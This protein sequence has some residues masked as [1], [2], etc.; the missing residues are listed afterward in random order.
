[1][2]KTRLL[3][4]TDIHGS[5]RCFV[6]FL[7]AGK[8]YKANV[9]I[10]GGD[11]TGKMLVP[12][13]KQKDGSY[14]VYFLGKDYVL[15]SSDEV[16]AFIQKVRAIGYYAY[17]TTRE[18]VE[19]FSRD[20]KK[21]SEIFERMIVETLERWMNIAEERLKGLEI[22]LF[23]SPG[24][25]D[26]HAVDEVLKKHECDKIIYCEE[27]VVH[28]D[29]HHEMISLGYSNITPWR[30]PRDISEEKFYEKIRNLASKIE[31]MENAIFN[32]HCPPAGTT[33]DVAPKLDEELKP[34]L[35]LG[36]QVIMVN[37]GSTAVRRAIEEFQPL[38]GL[39]GHIHE[40][41]GFFKIGR[42]L[43]INPGSEYSEGIL[44]GFLADLTEKKIKDYLFISG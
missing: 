9:L 8:M 6:K 36:G 44:R 14:S 10:L 27:K 35:G 17:L 29:D 16:E 24:N 43:C 22:K 3:F 12:L 33:L 7:N 38:L 2:P 21:L 28:I 18:E 4:S 37:V 19:E 13:I 40:S 1:M 25:D 20:A 30:C 11:L 32:I 39:H 31:N 42:T 26:I 5:E 34:I 41:K 15:N 23:I